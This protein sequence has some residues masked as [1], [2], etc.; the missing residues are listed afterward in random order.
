MLKRGKQISYRQQPY[1]DD[2][3]SS[4]AGR[5]TGTADEKQPGADKA[6][7]KSYDQIQRVAASVAATGHARPSDSAFVIEENYGDITTV[8]KKNTILALSKDKSTAGN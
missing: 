1:V 4:G 7:Y 5:N 8:M 6:Q 3:G 2:A